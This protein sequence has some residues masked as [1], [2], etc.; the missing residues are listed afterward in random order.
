MGRNRASKFKKHGNNNRSSSHSQPR[1]FVTSGY[2]FESYKPK[3][4]SVTPERRRQLE[5]ERKKREDFEKNFKCQF[6]STSNI[7]LYMAQ[8]LK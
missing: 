1:G 5:L 4:I 8:K 2:Q 6:E 3:S 7:D